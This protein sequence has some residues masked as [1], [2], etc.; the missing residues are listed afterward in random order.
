MST[1][2][3]EQTDSNKSEDQIMLNNIHHIGIIVRDIYETVKYFSEKLGI[4][5]KVMEMEHSG[6]LH[7]KP[8]KYKAKVA[9]A[10]MGIITLELLQTME[11]KNIFE[12][13]LKKNGEGIHHIA[14]ILQEDL[15]TEIEKWQKI[16]IKALQVDQISPGEGTAYMDVPGCIIELLCFKRMR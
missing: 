9:H 16:G 6:L 14:M 3:A 4:I 1:K 11:G 8:M 2:K 7:D 12:E 10:K 15:N 13:F 5:F